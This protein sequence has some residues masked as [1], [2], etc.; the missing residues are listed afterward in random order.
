MP[1]SYAFNLEDDC[2]KGL[3]GSEAGS[4]CSLPVA[5]PFTEAGKAKMTQAKVDE[6]HRAVTKFVVKGLH[7]FAT[8]D[9]LEFR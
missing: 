4:T 8:V 1:S 2:D 7:P 6:C 5:S 3:P 9:A